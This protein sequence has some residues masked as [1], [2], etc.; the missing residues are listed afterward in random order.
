MKDKES[1]TEMTWCATCE[2]WVQPATA[3]TVSLIGPTVVT[4]HRCPD[5]ESVL[6]PQSKP[7][8]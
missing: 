3:R 2:R 5:C 4:I 8:R 1:P 7:T 6:V